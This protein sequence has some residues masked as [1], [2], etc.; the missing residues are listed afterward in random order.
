MT[1]TVQQQ[2]DAELRIALLQSFAQFYTNLTGF[3]NKLN[4]HPNLKS[5]AIQNLDQGAM[6]AREAIS[7]LQFSPRPEDK[8]DFNN[9]AADEETQTKENATAEL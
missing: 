9:S 4:L 3:L 8:K 7:I 1:N 5:Y 6:W 2:N